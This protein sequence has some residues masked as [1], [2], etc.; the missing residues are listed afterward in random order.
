MRDW[1][2][3]AGCVLVG[4]VGLVAAMSLFPS[5]THTTFAVGTPVLVVGAGL[6][7]RAVRRSHGHPPGDE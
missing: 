4:F 6:G 1:I 5:A 2:V 3:Y 7:A